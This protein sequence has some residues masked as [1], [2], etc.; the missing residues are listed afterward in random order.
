MK[1]HVLW[2]DYY[3]ESHIVGIYTEEGKKKKIAELTEC[4]RKFFESFVNDLNFRLLK[5]QQ[6]RKPYAQAYEQICSEL[7]LNPDAKDLKDIKKELSKAIKDCDS[8]ICKLKVKIR[9]YSQDEKTI[10][11]LYMLDKNLNWIEEDVIE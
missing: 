2:Y 4:A 7:K 3:E 5:E 1:V 11:D 10:L 6:E 9:K 8:R